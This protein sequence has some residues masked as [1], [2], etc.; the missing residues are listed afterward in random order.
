MPRQRQRQFLHRNTAAIVTNT[1]ERQTAP[2]HLHLDG[3]GA[4][5]EAIL[6]QLFGDGSRTLD[7]L[8]GGDLVDQSGRQD[9]NR[10]PPL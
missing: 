8:A 3:A 4:S 7:H 10:H 9:T 6:D 1:N 2:L 5:V